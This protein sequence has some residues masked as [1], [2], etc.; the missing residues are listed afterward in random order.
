MMTQEQLL[1]EIARL[2]AR[3]FRMLFIRL[4]AAIR[5]GDP[6]FETDR[7][8]RKLSKEDKRAIAKS[9]S[10]T[11]K[12]EGHYMPMTKEEDREVILQYL[13]EKYR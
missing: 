11:F 4:S 5:E 6:E 3:D 1:K 8:K 9:L 13:E 2:P 7:F 12:P 10:G